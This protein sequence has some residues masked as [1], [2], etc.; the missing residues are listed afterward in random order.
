MDPL[1]STFRRPVQKNTRVEA[2]L[3][4]SSD[5][6]FCV[7]LKKTEIEDGRS[8]ATGLCTQNQARKTRGAGE[9]KG[10]PQEGG[11]TALS[12]EGLGVPSC[13]QV[14]L[15]PGAEGFPARRLPSPQEV[16]SFMK[17]S[18]RQTL[19]PLASLHLFVALAQRMPLSV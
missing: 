2:G 14:T 17:I 3:R 11:A 9:V 18:P 1:P 15:F 10:T 7:F 8:P 16:D 19:T 6:G 5:C 13:H 12:C 4:L